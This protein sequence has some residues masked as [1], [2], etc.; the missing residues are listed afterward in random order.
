MAAAAKPNI[1]YGKVN[2]YRKSPAKRFVA[3]QIAGKGPGGK[4][5]PFLAG[6]ILSA[7]AIPIATRLIDGSP[8]EQM[9]RQ[10]KIQKELEA[11]EMG[12]AGGMQGAS[13]NQLAGLIGGGESGGG[14][15]M[16]SLLEEEAAIRRA[17]KLGRSSAMVDRALAR[18]SGS[19]ELASLLAGDETRLRQLQSPRTLTP[20]ELQSILGIYE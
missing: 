18:P 17:R 1:N 12:M 4:M 20:Y 15:S 2:A 13:A 8:E 3:R 9:R 16:Q 5:L 11:E 14:R 7:A 6:T 10:F 19:D